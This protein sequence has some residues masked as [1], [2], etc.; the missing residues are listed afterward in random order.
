MRTPEANITCHIAKNA[1]LVE[2]DFLEAAGL[3]TRSSSTQIEFRHL[4]I[5]DT[6]RLNESEGL[7][8]DAANESGLLW[9]RKQIDAG[10]TTR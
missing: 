2:N 7:S 6:G 5:Q 4:L 1:N 3:T 10:R 9:I 8:F